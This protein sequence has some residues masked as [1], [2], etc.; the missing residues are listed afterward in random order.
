MISLVVMQ[1]AFVW[2]Y[3]R[4]L[5]SKI[6]RS[7]RE[8][9]L[10]SAQPRAAVI[11]CLRGTDPSLA[12][13]LNSLLAQDYPNFELHLVFDN[14]QDPA[15][16]VAQQL[17]AGEPTAKF[18]IS[19][20]RGGNRSLKCSSI[21]S[22]VL[23]L[24]TDVEI[25]ALVDADAIVDSDWLS[26]LVEPLNDPV[27]GA[28]TG[29]RWFAPESGGIG[30][31]FRKLWNAAALP[32]MSL[33]QIA[34]GGSLAIRRDVIENCHLLDHWSI[35]FCEDTM[36]SGK[37]AEHGMKVARIPDLIIV[38]RESTTLRDAVYWVGR[39]LLT[40]KLYDRRWILVITHA[41][42]GALCLFLPPLYCIYF[43]ISFQF[44][45]LSIIA[46]LWL[47]TQ[48]SNLVLIQWI[49]FAN[50]SA[51]LRKSANHNHAEGP[52]REIDLGP[53]CSTP[54]GFI[55]F[56]LLQML[57]PFLAIGASFQQ[58]VRWRGIDYRIG[59]RGRI[60]M[61]EYRPYSETLEPDKT[62]SDHS[63]H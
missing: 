36:L 46:G 30:P 7:G 27:I 38:N 23:N 13:C 59:R 20:D 56:V 14:H 19:E 48:L 32:Q 1:V 22:A 8:D 4:F 34:W 49:E 39:Q 35:A 45:N 21:I 47:F 15:L 11:L 37:L 28:T 18:H 16:A 6:K 42:I 41:I 2:L 58:R 5:R 63:I 24:D 53:L 54:S 40:V 62:G 51:I 43:L 33:Y 12:G 60:E 52:T 61:L 17:L 44:A 9:A 55:A 3:L 26:R 29:N 25:V 31:T 57:Y 50:R 10:S